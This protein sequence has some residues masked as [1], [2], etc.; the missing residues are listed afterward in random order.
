MYH[1]LLMEAKLSRERRGAADQSESE[2]DE[3]YLCVAANFTRG[4]LLKP[5]NTQSMN[6]PFNSVLKIEKLFHLRGFLKIG[7]MSK[8]QPG[9]AKLARSMKPRPG[10]PGSSGSI[11]SPILW[12]CPPRQ[13]LWVRVFSIQPP[14]VRNTEP[15]VVGPTNQQ[16]LP[17]QVDDRARLQLLWVYHR[18][19]AQSSF[20]LV[21]REYRYPGHLGVIT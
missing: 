20:S 5:S 10:R 11:T 6:M 19:C 8:T 9:Q 3:N 15:T 18:A 13:S 4:F 16:T 7:L 14:D 12:V 2:R 1:I 21:R 17:E